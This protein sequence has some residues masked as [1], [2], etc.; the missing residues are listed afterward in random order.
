MPEFRIE[1]VRDEYG[2]YAA[3]L[4]YPV[5]AKTPIGKTGAV[6]ASPDEVRRRIE[7]AFIAFFNAPARD[8]AR[9]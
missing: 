2:M 7:D 1:A 9:A 3:E 8:G 4:Y 6:Y 5:D